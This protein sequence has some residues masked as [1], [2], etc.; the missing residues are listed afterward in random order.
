[1]ETVL[2]SHLPPATGM[3]EALLQDLQQVPD[4]N[5]WQAPNQAALEAIL[6]PVAAP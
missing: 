4:A 2:S 3:T 6:S 5:P 1:V